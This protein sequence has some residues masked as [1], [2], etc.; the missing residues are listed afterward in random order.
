[1]AYRWMF[2]PQMLVVIPLALLLVLAVACGGGEEPETST[3]TTVTEADTATTAPSDGETMPTPTATPESAGAISPEGQPEFGGVVPMMAITAPISARV[4]P[5]TGYNSAQWNTR[6]YN[7]LVEYNPETTDPNDQRCD[8]CTSWDVSED[9]LTYTYHLHPNARWN[10]G[11]PV[12]AEDVVFSLNSIVDPTMPEF[13]DLWE[14]H[15]IRSTTGQLSL[16]YESGNARVID[17]KTVEV[18]LKFAA[19]AWHPTLGIEFMKIG[20]KHVVWDQRKHQTLASPDDMVGSGPLVYVKGSY[21]RDDQIEE[22]RNEDYFKSPEYPRIDGLKVFL[23]IDVGTIIAAY[24]SEQI[25]MGVANGDNIGSVESKQFEKDHGD[26]YDVYFVGPAGAYHVMFNAAKKPFDD[27][28]LRRAVHMA[29]HR[30][31]IM[32]IFGVGDL[33]LGSPFPPDTWFGPTSEEAAQMPGLRESEPGVKHPDD[34]AEAK[35]LLAE[36]G[37]PDG[38]GLS[39]VLTARS[40]ILYVDVATVV[41]AQLRETLDIDVKLNVVESSAGQAAYLAGDYQFAVQ[42]S[43]LSFTDPDAAF[44]GGRYTDGSLQGDEWGRGP[45]TTHW[46]RIQEI[47][48][49]QAREND[50]E[51]RKVLVNEASDLLLE[52][53]PFTPIFWSTSSMNFHKKIHNEHPVPSPFVS[54]WKWEH[55]WCDPAC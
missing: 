42:A 35:R 12:T 15:E 10:D 5:E 28:L 20:P 30:Q 41:A 14:G 25:L 44:S 4:W 43:G 6:M 32:D 7:N 24:A 55:I 3:P 34:I 13:G 1:M 23:M 48:N 54:S 21:I 31:A 51:K 50:P 37:F 49:A 8:L 39:V 11:V 9:G 46:A 29:V 27:P 16:Y 33:T 47:Y 18:T 40:A 19:A 52:D 38:K 17:D 26:R 53:S 36:A 22:R 2:K 45:L